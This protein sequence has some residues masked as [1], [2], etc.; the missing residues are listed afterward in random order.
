MTTHGIIEKAHER[1]HSP[2]NNPKPEHRI[3]NLEKEFMQLGSR[4]EEMSSDTAESLN[5][6][7]QDLTENVV[8]LR[9]DISKLEGKVDQGFRQAHAFINE[10]IASKEDLRKI[11]TRIDRIESTMATKEDLTAMKNEL[12]D[13]MKLLFQQRSSE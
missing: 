4:I 13:A 2:M 3:T 10:N 12:L 11:E 9:E 1:T 8:V 5:A 7:Q 6:L